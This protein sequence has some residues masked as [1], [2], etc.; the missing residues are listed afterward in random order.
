MVVSHSARPACSLTRISFRFF[1]TRQAVVHRN[2]KLLRLFWLSEAEAT[3]RLFM[4][5]SVRGRGQARHGG[6]LLSEALQ[7]S[8]DEKNVLG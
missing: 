2:P 1:P 3:V 4:K 6:I 8:M 7:T 5:D